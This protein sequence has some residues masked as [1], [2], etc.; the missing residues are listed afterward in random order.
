MDRCLC[1]LQA[2]TSD[3]LQIQ[4]KKKQNSSRH[5]NILLI[6]TRYI[7]IY[8][9]TAPMRACVNVKYDL[10]TIRLFVKRR[11]GVKVNIFFLLGVVYRGE[12]KAVSTVKTQSTARPFPSFMFYFRSALKKKEKKKERG[13][14]QDA[15][16]LCLLPL[17]NLRESFFGHQRLQC[18]QYCSLWYYNHH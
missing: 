14:N 10:R 7:W 4:G 18:A 5:F 17:P 11:S 2:C 16:F 6:Y 12:V 9:K 15:T 8:L 1:V 3:G 13:S